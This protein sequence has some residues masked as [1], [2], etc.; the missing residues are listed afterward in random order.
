MARAIKE[1][2]D[3][4]TE[5]Y[6]YALSFSV[7]YDDLRGIR[8]TFKE[9][10]FKRENYRYRSPVVVFNDFDMALAVK[11]AYGESIEQFVDLIK[12]KDIKV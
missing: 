4:D 2:K 3:V 7:G 8:S 5:I 6:R 11:M 9:L 12:L 1:L 10:G